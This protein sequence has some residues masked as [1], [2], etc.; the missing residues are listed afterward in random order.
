[1]QH[2]GDVALARERFLRTKPSN[3]TYLLETRYLW[4]NAF[5]EGKEQVI[6]I[7]AGAGFSKEFITNSSLVLTDFDSPHPWIEQRVD[8]MHMPYAADSL[9]VIISSHMIHHVAKPLV[10]FEEIHRVLKP[11]GLLLIH[12]VNT[13][14][15]FRLLLRVMR[16]EGWSYDVDVFDRRRVA[17]HP[18]DPWS[19]NCAIPEMLFS[20]PDR[21]HRA[22]PGLKVIRNELC[23]CFIFPLSGGVIA[24][25]RTVNLPR[26]L[27]EGV[28]AIDALLVRMLPSVF[29]LGRRVVLEKV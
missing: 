26:M 12:D 24:K 22:L 21:F 10:L 9:D 18:E 6:E 3:L 15:V 25:S 7:G 27:L 2:E 28:N 17:N 16:H 5:C 1:M 23:E 29:A 8:A 14:L 11:G 20:D 19:A 4:M 13:S